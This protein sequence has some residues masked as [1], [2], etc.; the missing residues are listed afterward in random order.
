MPRP[1][2]IWAI[3]SMLGPG[4]CRQEPF[5]QLPKPLVCWHGCCKKRG[6]G[7]RDNHWYC[8][9]HLVETPIR[10]IG[11]CSST[12]TPYVHT[13]RKQGNLEN[14][15]FRFWIGDKWNANGYATCRC[16]R[17]IVFNKAGRDDHKDKFEYP[18]CFVMLTNAYKEL[19]KKGRCLVCREGTMQ[20]NW[21]VPI[22]AGCEDA[23]K[24]HTTEK[25][26]LLEQELFRQFG[27]RKV[28]VL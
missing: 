1:M 5:K 22:C 2:P 23:W 14:W 4:G 6:V 21:G 18:N 17:A 20:R 24:F 19:L 3:R 28:V 11:F 27:E 8:D 13:P 9:E 15:E 12:F 16:C 25:F 26:L 10:P 7:L